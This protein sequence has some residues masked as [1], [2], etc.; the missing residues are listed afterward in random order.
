M[1]T[2]RRLARAAAA[3]ASAA[4]VRQ[5]APLL[6]V[7]EYGGARSEERGLTGVIASEAKQSIVTMPRYGL[8]RFARNDSIRGRGCY[9]DGQAMHADAVAPK[10]TCP[11]G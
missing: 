10:K 5:P 9:I 6:F 2:Y 11:T 7:S 3:A 4:G 1:T 8:L